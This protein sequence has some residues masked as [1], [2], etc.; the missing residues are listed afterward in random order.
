MPST[1]ATLAQ[2]TGTVAAQTQVTD[3]AAE[4]ENEPVQVSFV[5]IQ[6]K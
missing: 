2:M 3:T 6:K 4:T 1:A 5:P